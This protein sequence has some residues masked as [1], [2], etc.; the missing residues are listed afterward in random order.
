MVGREESKRERYMRLLCEKTRELG[1]KVTSAEVA[2]DSRLP[3]PNDYAF[4]MRSF[5][6]AAEAAWRTV[7]CESQ[8]SKLSSVVK[9]NVSSAI[10]AEVVETEEPAPPEIYQAVLERAL[11]VCEELGYVP[12]KIQVWRKRFD[13]GKLVQVLG[14]KDW[15]RALR[16]V[17]DAW[18]ER[19][20]ELKQESSDLL[21]LAELD[22][23]RE[24][25]LGWLKSLEVQGCPEADFGR[26]QFVK[27]NYYAQ[28]R[29]ILELFGDWSEAMRY[30]GQFRK[31]DKGVPDKVSD[32]LVQ[33]NTAT[34]RYDVDSM[35]KLLQVMTITLGRVPTAMDYRRHVGEF[36]GPPY[37]EMQKIVGKANTWVEFLQVPK[38]A[39]APEPEQDR[40]SEKK[41]EVVVEPEVLELRQG[42]MK[43]EVKMLEIT[44]EREETDESTGV[45]AKPEVAKV[46]ELRSRRRQVRMSLEEMR[47]YVLEAM[48]VL[49]ERVTTREYKEYLTKHPG[50]S[51][52]TLRN[53][54]LHL[55]QWPQIAAEAKVGEGSK[56][57][58][59]LEAEAKKTAEAAT[60]EE[61][62]K[63]Q[64]EPEVQRSPEIQNEPVV[65]RTE[66]VKSGSGSQSKAVAQGVDL[67]KI[68][69]VMIHG[70]DATVTLGDL[71][72][73]M[74]LDFGSK[75]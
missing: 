71:E 26:F 35:K 34:S 36:D 9:D 38:A 57:A 64:S 45:I 19:H 55:T 13:S 32:A 22:W 60:E 56:R 65:Q 17:Q 43:E 49:G 63:P 75:R 10:K 39:V 54:G 50:P 18:D 51:L 41:L 68:L 48:K 61:A 73:Q 28:M 11:A 7:Q 5:D 30:L 58:V 2:A 15:N 72:I 4:Y 62:E 23:Q 37:D 52:N 20:P 12:H 25:W 67:A 66:E 70:I 3:A 8:G 47:T 69:Q 46:A 24:E 16:V 14:K 1:R 40:V 59:E 44:E 29:R 31:S 6:E 21:S 27:A 42:E 74:R 53:Y 33:V